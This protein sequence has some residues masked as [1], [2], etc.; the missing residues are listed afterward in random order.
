RVDVRRVV[1]AIP[2]VGRPRAARLGHRHLAVQ[3]HGPDPAEHRDE[4]QAGQ[5]PAGGQ[6]L[7]RPQQGARRRPG[8]PRLSEA[9][10]WR[11]GALRCVSTGERRCRCGRDVITRRD[12]SGPASEGRAMSYDYI[13]VGAGSAGCALAARLSEDS[14][15][16]VLLLE[17]GPEDKSR[18]IHW[19]VGFYKMTSGPLTWGLKTAP[20]RHA[21]NREI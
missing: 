5:Q 13:V 8:V 2:A 9:G 20:Q 7:R 21:M 11:E 18:F 12:R 1:P 4:A 16:S 3:R 15:C 14:G 10:V 6:D 19:P 17:A